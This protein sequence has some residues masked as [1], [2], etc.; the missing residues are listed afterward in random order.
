MSEHEL[1]SGPPR[2]PLSLLP[3]ATN[4]PFNSY[5]RQHEPTCLPDTRVN[6]LQQI[7]DWADG[8]DG[9]DQRCIFW[10]KGLAGTGK[11]TISCTVAH[12]FSEQKRLGASF[13]FS[14][15]SGDVSNAGKFFTSLAVQLTFNVPSLRQYILEA[16]TK[17]SDIA[18]L[19]LSEQWRQLVLS[20]LSILQS[21]S[22][23]SYIL[24]VD[25]LDECED[26]KDVRTILRLLAEARSLTT[27]RLRVFLTSRPENQ[28]RYCIDYDIQSDHQDFELHSV[29]ST[30]VNHDISLFLEYNLGN[31]GQELALGVDWPGEVVR[32]QLV[33]YACGLF[34]WASTAYRF[35][36]NGKQF[37][38]KRLDQ[39]LKG[40]SG[41]ITA[42]EKHLDEIYLTTLKHSISPEFSDEEKEEA[43]DTLKHTLGV[44]VVLLSPLSTS[45]LRRLLPK[46]DVESAFSDLYAILD[47]PKDPT[48]QLRLHHPSF[49]DFL[50]NKDRCREFWVDEKEAHQVLATSCM[51]L[52]S[53]TLK[54]DICELH[55]PGYQATQVESSCVQ[56]F[57]P[58]EVQYACLYWVQHL[59]RSGSQVCDGGEAH[60]FLEKHLLHWLEALGWMGKTSEGIQAILSLEA[61]ILV[62]RLIEALFLIEQAPLQLY[63]SALIFTPEKSI[64][65]ITFEKC[66]PPWIQIKP[67]VQ[68][69]WSAALQTLEGHSRVVTSVAF[70]PDGKQ[71]VSGS[72]DDTTVRLWDA[73]TGAALQTLEGHSDSV[74]LT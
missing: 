65:R 56:K 19:S 40:S 38:R 15:G 27:V 69:H 4:A 44:L 12:R 25:A 60:Q 48:R 1:P 74:V 52:M 22:C 59:Q 70:S 63:C 34:I 50:L 18:S 9:Q 68:A 11:S 5:F 6:L 23:Q 66:I 3:F 64:V 14:K 71:V 10:L 33:L 17:R 20:P 55:A 43:R 51:Q 67:K 30:I 54:K 36:N 24:V 53:G 35:I 32:R 57:L 13:L 47:I 28:I 72:W 41:T 2:S 21:E 37:A 16:V 73:V 46:K 7:Y 58:P 39:I 49:R 8:K 31:I 45:S 62:V 26:D 42:P 29:S 61:H